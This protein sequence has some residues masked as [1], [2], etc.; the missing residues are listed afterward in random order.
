METRRIALKVDVDTLR[1]TLEGVPALVAAMSR[2][3]AGGS[4]Y[5]SLGPDHTG[6]ALKRVF[7]FSHLETGRPALDAEPVVEIGAHP[8]GALMAVHVLQQQARKFMAK[9]RDD[10]SLTV[11]AR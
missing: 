6:R 4:F 5:F 7:D 1:G 10:H 11:A 8:V 9:N 3:Q 2:L